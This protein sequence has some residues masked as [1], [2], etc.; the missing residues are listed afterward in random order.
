MVAAW[1]DSEPHNSQDP[2]KP[3]DLAY[4]PWPP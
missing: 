1:S 3:N 4:E 2:G